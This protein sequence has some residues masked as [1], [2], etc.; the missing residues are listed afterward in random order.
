MYGLNTPTSDVDLKGIY[1]PSHRDI[2]LGNVPKTSINTST[3]E[4][5]SKNSKD[6]IDQEMFTLM[7]F[8]RM[9]EQG[10]TA[11]IDMLFCPAEMIIESSY[12]WDFI[13]EN[14]DKL[15]TGKAS[16][17]IGYCF[18]QANKYGIKGSRIKAMKEVI[19]NLSFNLGDQRIKDTK[20]IKE[21]HKIDNDH[22]KMIKHK[23]SNGEIADYLEVCG[24]KFGMMDKVDHVIEV[25]TM[26][27]GKYGDRARLAEKN[28]GVDW[29]AL[30][31]ALR[32]CYEAQELLATGHVTLPFTGSKR[33]LLLD[34]KQGLLDY[35]DVSPIIEEEMEKVKLLEKTCTL[36]EKIDKKFWED[37][38][39]KTYSR[40]G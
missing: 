2:I 1:I 5:N 8:I 36:P 17:F 13:Q 6:D 30:S 9:C 11:A 15:I 37:F 22:V 28:E 32:V 10:Q 29:K 31:H 38:I 35:K 19:E 25:L 21:L 40:Q 33:N 26:I 34:I 18:Q 27:E 14:R 3:G 23:S 39:Y 16:S 12:E 7:G 24:R 20:L 4:D